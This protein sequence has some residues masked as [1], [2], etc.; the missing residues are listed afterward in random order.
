MGKGS[1]KL[2]H[3]VIRVDQ[4]LLQPVCSRPKRRKKK[5]KGARMKATHYI[6][7]ETGEKVV[8]LRMEDQELGMARSSKEI[9]DIVVHIIAQEIA[10]MILLKIW[11]GID[12][13]LSG[14]EI[15][16]STRVDERGNASTE[17]GKAGK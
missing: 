2:V 8:E 3:D 12:A 9:M 4:A 17:N 14:A 16:N 11:P 6:D 15:G 7:R 10:A 13:V 5:E 1:G